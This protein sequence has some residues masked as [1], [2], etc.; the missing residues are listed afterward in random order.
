MFYSAWRPPPAWACPR[1]RLA[2]AG[3]QQFPDFAHPAF[4]VTWNRT[5]SLVAEGRVA[6]SWYW[7]PQANTAGLSE[8]L[9]DAADGTR[10]HLVQYFDK[11][12]MEINDPNGDRTT[13]SM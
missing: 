6:R 11:S 8:T 2:G 13:R 1:S 5:D 3:A 4:E 12:R 10:Q 7:G 9:T